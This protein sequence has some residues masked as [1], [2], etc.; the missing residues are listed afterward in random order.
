VSAVLFDEPLTVIDPHLKWQLRRKLKQI[1]HTEYAGF[2]RIDGGFALVMH[3]ACR[4]GEIVNP[5]D[6]EFKRVNDIV[7]H[8][9]EAGIAN[10]MLDIRLTTS[11]EIIEADDFVPLLDKAV[12]EVRSKESGSAGNENTHW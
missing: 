11:E 3:R 6:L 4:A 5:V 7:A 10:K 12:A 8:E 9:L 2:H 1:Q